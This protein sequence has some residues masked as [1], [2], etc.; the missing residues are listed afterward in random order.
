MF[1]LE[2]LYFKLHLVSRIY[3]WC[4]N[5]GWTLA[6]SHEK[7]MQGYSTY[8]VVTW[9]RM[10]GGADPST[11]Q[12]ALTRVKTICSTYHA[13]AA[14]LRDGTVVTWGIRTTVVILLLSRRR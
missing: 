6:A 14:V 8:E 5:L 11:L 1:W 13:F 7:I 3:V 2:V 4:L 10:N 9:G 12:R